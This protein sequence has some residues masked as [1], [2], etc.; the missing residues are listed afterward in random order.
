MGG[1][2]F[3]PLGVGV[4]YNAL[5]TGVIVRY[6]RWLCAAWL[7]WQLFSDHTMQKQARFVLCLKLSPYIDLNLYEFLGFYCFSSYISKCSELY[8]KIHYNLLPSQEL[9]V[10]EAGL[11]VLGKETGHN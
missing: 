8:I 5:C 1:G 3:V 11:K 7:S 10:S 4:V 6:L 2:W 9:V